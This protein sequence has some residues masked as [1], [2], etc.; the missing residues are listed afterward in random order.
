M[1]IQYPEN[2][3]AEVRQRVAGRNFGF[4]AFRGFDEGPVR[5]RNYGKRL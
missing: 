1:I 4:G 5:N 3:L 2:L